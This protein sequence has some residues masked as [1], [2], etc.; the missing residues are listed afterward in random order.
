MLRLFR[1]KKTF[2]IEAFIQ[3]SVEGLRLVTEAHK[4]NWRFGQERSWSVNEEEGRIQFNFADGIVASAPA[5]VIGTFHSDD[6]TFTWGW[7]H[8]AVVPNLKHHAVRVKAFGEQYDSRELTTPTVPCT[9]KR[10]WEY[11]ALAMLLAEANGAYR[12]QT[13]PDTFAFMTFGA[14]EFSRQA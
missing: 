1:K 7:E 11:T 8:P 14:V 4:A 3:G 13:G 10:A 9:A 5:Q 6:N 12:A 2:D